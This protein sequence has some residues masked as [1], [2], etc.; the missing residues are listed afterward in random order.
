MSAEPTR[1]LGSLADARRR[2]R[3]VRGR[4]RPRDLARRR[5]HDAA[6]RRPRLRRR[7]PGARRERRPARATSPRSSPTTSSRARSGSSRATSRSTDRMMLDGRRRVDGRR[8]RAL[9]GAQRGGAREAAPRPAGPPRRRRSTARSSRSYAADGVIVATPTGSTA[10]SFSA[11]GPIV[12]PR[13]RCLLLTPVSP[14]MLFD[15]S[16]VLDADEE[17]RF[18]VTDDR[19]AVAHDR[20]PRARRA[21][22][23]RPRDVH[24]RPEGPA[25]IVTFGPRD[26]HQILKAKFGLGGPVTADADRAAHREPRHHRRAPGARSARGSPRSPARPARARRSL[27]EALELLLGGAGRH[28]ARPRRRDRGA[29]RGPVRGRR[30]RGGRARARACPPTGGRSRAYVDGRLATAAELADGRRDARRPARPARAPVAA[31]AG[32]CSARRS[33]GS[34]AAARA[35]PRSTR[36]RA[37]RAEL[38]GDRRRAGRARRRRPGPCPRA[39]PAAV[40]DRRDRR[41]RARRPRRGRSRSKPKRRCSRDA[42]GAP[43][44]AGAAHTTRSTAA[45]YDAVGVAAGALADR[46]ARSSTLVEPAPVGAAGRA[47]RARRSE[48]RLAAERVVDDPER[49]E[50][51]RARR[52]LLRELQRKYGDTLAEVLD[53]RGRGPRPP[54]RAR[55]LRGPRRR[56]RGGA[57]RRPRRTKPPRTSGCRRPAAAAAGPLGTQVTGHLARPRHAGGPRSTWWSQPATPGEDGADDVTF[58]LAAESGRTGPPPGQGRVRRRALAGDAGAPA[59]CCPRRRPTLVFDEV[60]AGI[61]GEAGAAVGRARWPSWR[62][63]TRCC[64]SPTSPRSRRAPTPRSRCRRASTTA[65]RSPARRRVDGDARVTELSRMLAGVGSDPRPPARRRAARIGARRASRRRPD[66]ARSPS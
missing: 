17:L 16:L 62:G 22:A 31:R 28:V 13:H 49:L 8:R 57:N 3:R 65:G 61:G 10:Y 58:L 7:R 59:A 32:R 35:Q 66:G 47:R 23:G 41:G 34:P 15:R 20:R 25:R 51:V 39:R 14:H 40:P 11:R 9:V 45:A 64:A 54:R 29:G 52:Q 18:T 26:F 6:H 53:L 30:R 48:L 1:P 24:R 19:H 2:P 21:R 42:A 12:S 43:G 44:G 27:V 38:R 63:A 33:T 46:S 5:R 4:P 55:G 50:A 36:Y 37:A 56:A 60:D